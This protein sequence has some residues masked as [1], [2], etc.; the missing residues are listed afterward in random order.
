MI[1]ASSRPSSAGIQPDGLVPAAVRCVGLAFLATVFSIVAYAQD[2]VMAVPQ[3]V[4]VAPVQR[5]QSAPPPLSRPGGPPQTPFQI[6]PV[7]LRPHVLY[8]HV[9]AE[10]LQ[11]APGLTVDT[12]I[13][14]VAAGL[15]ADLGSNWTIDYTPT[16]T[17]YS[18]RLYRD[19]V[20]HLANL[21]GALAYENWALF[22]SE[23]Y[24]VA[25]PI[26]IETAQQTKQRS[27]ATELGATYNFGPALQFRTTAD[28]NEQYA[29]ITPDT[30]EWSTTNWLTYRYSPHLDV[31]AG[32]GLGYVDI[33]ALPDMQ[34]QRYLG[35]INWRIA[36]KLV[37]SSEGGVE[38]RQSRSAA[39]ADMNNP[40]L[41]ASLTYTPFATTQLVITH[42]RAVANSFFQ[43][44]LTKSSTWS[45]SLNQRLLEHLFLSSTYSRQTVD[46]TTITGLAGPPRGDRVRSFNARLMTAP[47]L[48]RWIA[49]VT[50]QRIQDRSNLAIFN[51]TSTQ[52]GIELSCRF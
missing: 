17:N 31:A 14:T 49:A 38:R 36:E 41:Q 24:S 2:A 48:K 46:Y 45:T 8:R 1:F 16:W 26:L 39:V 19:T 6:G 22:M 12:D 11:V 32:L 27:W 5:A 44:D 34:Y 40:L 30:R 10:G 20:D 37:L 43:A 25:S 4:L 29:D 7:S 50:Y 3:E 18:T 9:R 52:Y 15:Q 47:M 28:L 33:V 23:T 42:A 51:F 21:R 13:D 35:R